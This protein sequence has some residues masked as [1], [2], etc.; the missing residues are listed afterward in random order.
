MSLISLINQRKH[1]SLR[2]STHHLLLTQ[3]SKLI[4]CR[5][6]AS[7]EFGFPVL[8]TFS[9]AYIRIAQVKFS[10]CLEVQLIVKHCGKLRLLHFY[11]V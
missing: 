1:S 2:T 10:S 8:L 5:S 4:K 3:L 11:V 6:I 9:V 7:I